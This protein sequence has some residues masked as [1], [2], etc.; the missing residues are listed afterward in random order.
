MIA[1]K[2]EQ[3]RATRSRGGVK[4]AVTVLVAALGVA[5][6]GGTAL[7]ATAEPKN[8]PVTAVQA[9]AV[10]QGAKKPGFYETYRGRHIMGWGTGDSACA[11]INGRRLVVY[12]APNGQFTSAIQAFAPV[13]GL[14]NITKASVKALGENQLS[15]NAEPSE[16]CPAFATAPKPAPS[17]STP[18]AA[19][20]KPAVEAPK[21]AKS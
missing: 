17:A 8:T 1:M 11:Y 19:A 14:R 21:P 13:T 5:A 15:D 16:T 20:S 2:Q 10:D 12:S 7:A 18:A 9:P 3:Q 6:A 4:R